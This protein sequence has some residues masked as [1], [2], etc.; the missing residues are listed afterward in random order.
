MS[1]RVTGG[2]IR[3]LSP[4]SVLYVRRNSPAVTICQNTSKSTVFLEAVGQSAQQ[5]DAPPAEITGIT[6]NPWNTLVLYQYFLKFFPPLFFVVS[7][8]SHL[9]HV[10][11][12]KPQLALEWSGIVIV[13]NQ[14]AYHP[15]CNQLK[16]NVGA[17][18]GCALFLSPAWEENK[19]SLFRF[20]LDYVI[21]LVI[22]LHFHSNWIQ[23]LPFIFLKAANVSDMLNLCN[24]SEVKLT[25]ILISYYPSRSYF[26][27][28]PERFLS[29]FCPVVFAALHHC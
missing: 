17:L 27:L 15:V 19:I 10:S 2:P 22:A 11:W 6:G 16:V 13:R 26:S 25:W 23:E 5:T 7:S 20:S 3:G 28:G 4:T 29:R 8:A 12:S 24:V 1:C 21:R 9:E 14:H 18:V